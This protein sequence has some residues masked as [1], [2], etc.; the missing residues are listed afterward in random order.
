M[1]I[2][3]G[4]VF[5]A[6]TDDD[7]AELRS[8]VD[9]IG[10]RS[11]TD[12]IGRRGLPEA[13]DTA[14]WR[15]LEDTGLSRLTGTA[16]LGA[17]PAEAAVVLR[18]LARHAVAVPAAETDLLA[19][20][21]AGRAGLAVPD[22]GPLTLAQAD[23]LDGVAG[24]VPWAATAVAIVLAVRDGNRL[25]VAALGAGDTEITEGHNIGGEPRD[26]ISFD[27][28]PNDFHEL[29]AAVGDELRRR[30]AWA[31]CVQCVGTLDAAAELTVAHTRDRVQFGR[32]LS[33]FQ[34]VQHALAG[35]AGEIERARAATEIAVA[36]ASDYGFDAAHTD[37]AVTIAKITLGRVV[38]AVS[39][40]AHQLHGAIGVTLEHPLWSAT[41]RALSWVEE[42]GSTGWY[43][44]RLG[45][46]ALSAADDQLWDVLITGS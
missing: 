22:T 37:H 39:T 7:F 40:I 33:Q 15:N 46:L 28:S 9:D 8:L 10:A 36:A 30:G 14:A 38:P 27:L 16:E 2:L 44:R 4:G 13:F 41:N 11:A 1:S 29:D 5:A 17:G 6:D 21:L 34:A 26:T 45:R 42:F 12:R 32:A 43:A 25:L 20:W 3:A 31:R 23:V 35:M 19:G 18:G 24:R